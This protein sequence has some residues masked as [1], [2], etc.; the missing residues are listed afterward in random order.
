MQI[1]FNQILILEKVPKE[2]GILSITPLHKKGNPLDPANYRFI[3]LVNCIAK[4]FTSI[5]NHRLKSFVERYNIIPE[6]QA[7]FRHNRGCEDN[8]FTLNSLLQIHG[9]IQGHSVYGLFVEFR[10]AFD[11]IDHN[12]RF[13]KLEKLVISSKV[14]NIL[15]DFYGT[16][17]AFVKVNNDYTNSVR[18]SRRVLQGKI[19]SPC[20]SPCS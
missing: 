9:R 2:W 16:A 6:M 8:F 12:I 15:K 1:L 19:L 18:V 11:S 4:I 7:G 17:T 5:I 10:K 20:Y 14:I 13:T 3:T